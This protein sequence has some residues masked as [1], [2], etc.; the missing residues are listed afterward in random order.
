[1]SEKKVKTEKAT[2]MGLA[3][4]A[5]SSGINLIIKDNLITGLILV[6]IGIGLLILRE[7]LK[8]HRWKHLVGSN[9]A[10]RGKPQ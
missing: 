6:A 7:H 2:I 4:L 8:F 1:V 3:I 9:S 5:L 10:W